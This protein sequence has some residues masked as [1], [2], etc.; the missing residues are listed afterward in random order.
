MATHLYT[1][2]SPVREKD[3]E[4]I[5]ATL[6]DDGVIAM[7]MDVAWSFVCDA[8][9]SK[10][11]DRIH[12]L[13]LTH[14]KDRPFSL[15]CDSI[16]MAA[17]LANIDNSSYRWLKKSLPGPYTILLESHVSLPK[18]IHD[19]RKVVGIRLPECEI[20]RAVVARSKR[21]LA[22]STIMLH[23]EDAEAPK[24]HPGFGWEV[25]EIYGHALDMIVDLG[26]ES[27]RQETTIIDLTEGAPKLVR[28]GAGDP[29][30]FDL[31]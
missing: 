19:K 8:A 12:R 18:I 11:L 14:P 29:K 2:I 3:I 5:C 6:E 21:P 23:G 31:L 28:S 7:P 25:N 13:K 15:V 22:T 27:P 30:L 24:I 17:K 26:E 20:V 1:Y 4:A 9:S 16:S 10:A